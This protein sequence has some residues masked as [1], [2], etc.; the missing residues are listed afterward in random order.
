MPRDRTKS[1]FCDRNSVY[2]RL[3]AILGPIVT[4]TL[5]ER[6]GG[7]LVY[8]RMNP[9]GGPGDSLSAAIGL[10]HARLLATH[11]GGEKL[12]LPVYRS[13]CRETRTR[14]AR[15][16]E[17]AGRGLTAPAIAVA[18]GCTQRWVNFVLNG[19]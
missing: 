4:D 6:F 14:T 11:F 19:K 1:G 3:I 8:I 13:P 17:L 16:C 18:V 15:I 10:E 7:R 9:D 12:S 2:N 5:L